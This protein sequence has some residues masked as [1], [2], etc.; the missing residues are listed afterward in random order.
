MGLAYLFITHNI[1]VVD[2][3]AREVAVMY[4]GRIVENGPADAIL[5][6]PAHPYTRALLSAVPRI[7]GERQSGGMLG[8]GDLPSAFDPPPGCHFQPRCPQA[9]EK[10]KREYPGTS[11]IGAGHAVRCHLYDVRSKGTG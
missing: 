5:R 2:F 3:L 10:C 11:M 7:D 8:T 4:L 6:A 1:A 9:T